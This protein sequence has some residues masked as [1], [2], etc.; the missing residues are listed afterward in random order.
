[1]LSA[2]CL[3]EAARTEAAAVPTMRCQRPEA[4][5]LEAA[6]RR[7]RRR[8]CDS[9]R[10]SLAREHAHERAVGGGGC[11]GGG[12]SGARWQRRAM[13]EERN[14]AAQAG[15]DDVIVLFIRHGGGQAKCTQHL[16][17]RHRV[18]CDCG[19]NPS[20]QTRPL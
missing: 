9:C 1:M 16:L 6:V 10:A 5:R 12:G 8:S 4:S 11:G 19:R 18:R 20:R 2:S 3:A 13:R 17:R 15:R 7:T 14:R